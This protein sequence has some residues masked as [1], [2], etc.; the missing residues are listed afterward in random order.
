MARRVRRM[1]TGPLQY[2]ARALRPQGHG[3]PAPPRQASWAAVHSNGPGAVGRGLPM[4]PRRH[5][6]AWRCLL[7]RASAAHSGRAPTRGPHPSPPEPDAQAACR[8]ARRGRASALNSSSGGSSDA[9]RRECSAFHACSPANC[10]RTEPE[11]WLY[12]TGNRRVVR[13]G[14]AAEAAAACNANCERVGTLGAQ[15][16]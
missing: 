16:R 15:W 7:R 13:T 8:R 3:G 14:D 4:A 6:S 12:L 5:H 9:S 10:S 2:L 1:R 11:P